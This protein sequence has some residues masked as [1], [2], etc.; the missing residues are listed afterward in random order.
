MEYSFSQKVTKEDYVS[1]VTNHMKMSFLKPLNIVLFAVSIGYL[2]VS[3]FIL[4]DGNFTFLFI[5]LAI[6]LL[7]VGMVLYARKNAA[8]QYMKDEDQ[9][10]MD[11]EVN[12]KGLV[13]IY[14]DGRLEK[15]WVDFYST[16][17]T[18]DYIYVYVNKNSGLVLVKRDISTDGVRFIKEKLRENIVPKRVKFLKGE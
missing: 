3:P 12:D 11:Y 2:M 18:E 7:L 15:L 8:K 16:A 13:Y 17:E 6:L 5:G 9:F 1:F 4:Q 14:N 10:N